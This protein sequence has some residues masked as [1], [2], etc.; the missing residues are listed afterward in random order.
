MELEKRNRK[1]KKIK[2]RVL[3]KVYATMTKN[4][5]AKP[6][7]ENKRNVNNYFARQ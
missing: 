1:W 3:M 7:R 2:E 4:Q 5:S 6:W